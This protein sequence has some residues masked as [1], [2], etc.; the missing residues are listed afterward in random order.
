MKN[1]LLIGGAVRNVGKTTY[2]CRL[3]EKF[4][5]EH[6][7]VGLKIKTVYEGDNKFHGKS[8]N[9]LTGNFMLKEESSLISKED[10]GKMLRAGAKRAFQLKVKSDAL[11]EAFI[12]FTDKI[13]DNA[14][15]I[16][17]SN[18]LRKV[19]KPGLF[20]LIKHQN[21]NEMKPSA[22]ELEKFADKIIY[23]DGKNHDLPLEAISFNKDGWNI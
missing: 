22:K 21:N 2:V 19:I 15:I 13:K 12:D 7:V 4:S 17:E 23:T 14:I 20:L 10:T 5:K 3:I 8:R 16:C 6:D 1:L 11:E 18:S 9:P